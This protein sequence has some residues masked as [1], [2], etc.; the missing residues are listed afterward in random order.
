MSSTTKSSGVRQPPDVTCEVGISDSP[1]QLVREILKR[2]GPIARDINAGEEDT[3]ATVLSVMLRVQAP[4]A[5]LLMVDEEHC[6]RL[7]PAPPLSGFRG[8]GASP[9]EPATAAV[10]RPAP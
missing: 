6:E 1:T 8:T 5:S 2:R 9:K 3:A 10:S 7:G 4:P